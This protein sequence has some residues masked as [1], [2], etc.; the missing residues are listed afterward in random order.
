MSYKYNPF[1][2][3]LDLTNPE[4]FSHNNI[5]STETVTIPT[6]QQMLVYKEITIDGVLIIDGEL[7]VFDIEPFNRIIN[8]AAS[9]SINIE[10][11]EVIKQ[12]ASGITTSISG[13]ETGSKVTITNRSGGDNTINLTV[14]GDVS[15]TISDGES[16]SLVYSGTEY[17]L[18]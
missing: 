11:Y 15:P 2:D 7:F 12:T 1:T 8:T 13:A 17:E 14:Q 9:E 4:N 16:F 18:V 3:K 5:A 6:G 10:L